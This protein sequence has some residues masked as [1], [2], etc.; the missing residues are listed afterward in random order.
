MYLSIL[1]VSQT[2]QRRVVGWFVDN[3]LEK[4]WTEAVMAYLKLPWS[5]HG[6]TKYT[7]KNLTQDNRCSGRDLN[8]VSPKY[9]QG[10]LPYQP[11]RG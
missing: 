5:F 9:T 1:S 7:S 6:W 2:V 4:V 8:G 10:A 11:A 3:E